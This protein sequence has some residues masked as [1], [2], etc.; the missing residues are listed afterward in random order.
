M[1]SF[2]RQ[3]ANRLPDRGF[4]TPTFFHRR[5]MPGRQILSLSPAG[6]II[7]I[8]SHHR[9]AGDSWLGTHCDHD[10][11]LQLTWKCCKFTLH[12]EK[13]TGDVEILVILTSSWAGRFLVKLWRG[14]PRH[15]DP[16]TKPVTQKTASSSIALARSHIVAV[17]DGLGHTYGH[18][19]IGV[20]FCGKN[21]Q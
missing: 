2:F 21:L 14:W 3:S 7:A 8:L 6:E 9:G 4:T 5:A 10:C 15:H 1:S 20:Q 11:R 18:V 13:F 17:S 16:P 19:N 12:W